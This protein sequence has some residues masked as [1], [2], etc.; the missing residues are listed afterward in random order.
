MGRAESRIKHRR[1]ADYPLVVRLFTLSDSCATFLHAKADARST[2]RPRDRHNKAL[3][4][5]SPPM[6]SPPFVSETVTVQVDV[7]P[8]SSGSPPPT[9]GLRKQSVVSVDDK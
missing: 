5:V 2:R 3:P 4:Q 1:R 8:S 7:L 9:G 6:V